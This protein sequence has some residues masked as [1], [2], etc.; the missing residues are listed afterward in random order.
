MTTTMAITL[1]VTL[2]VGF[3]LIRFNDGTKG[4]DES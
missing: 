2:L 3:L 1:G 4:K